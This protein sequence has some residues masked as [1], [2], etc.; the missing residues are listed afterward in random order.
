MKHRFK[1]KCTSFYQTLK[2]LVGKGQGLEFV[3]K[4]HVLN[5]FRA[6]TLRKKSSYH[7]IILKIFVN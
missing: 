4:Y 6:S 7:F 2:L 5:D 1:K 3:M